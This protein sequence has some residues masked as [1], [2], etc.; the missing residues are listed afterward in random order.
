MSSSTLVP[1]YNIGRICASILSI[2]HADY[3]LRLVIVVKPLYITFLIYEE[4][5]ALVS[6]PMLKNSFGEFWAD[7]WVA[8]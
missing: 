3:I 8:L 5:F 7:V 4:Q 2:N 1:V 6:K